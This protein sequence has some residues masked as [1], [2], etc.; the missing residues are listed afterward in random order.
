MSYAL[1]QNAASGVQ[2]GS[3][4][5]SDPVLARASLE[6]AQLLTKSV[7]QP[8]QTRAAFILHSVNQKYNAK[9]ANAYQAKLRAGGGDQRVYD[10]LRL[11]IADYYVIVGLRYLQDRLKA[12]YGDGFAPSALGALG[13]APP[14][15]N[16]GRD[17]G[18]AIGGGATVLLSAIVGAYTA[19]AGAPLVGAGGQIAMSAAGCGAAGQAAQGAL[20]AAQAAAAQAELE[21]QARAE[22]EA[23]ASRAKMIK[24]GVIVGGL[25]VAGVVGYVILGT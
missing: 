7:R 1:G 3:R 4:A 23:A 24:I 17:V 2:V 8:R 9:T 15:D 10:A 25:A 5:Y 12:K 19:G 21:R 13:T 6:A 11:A 20:T 16:T 22:A 14:P 18:C